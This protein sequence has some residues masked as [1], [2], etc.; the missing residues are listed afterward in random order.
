MQEQSRPFLKHSLKGNQGVTSVSFH[1]FSTITELK[2]S[3]DCQEETLPSF[4]SEIL[5]THVDGTIKLWQLD[6]L[7]G[8]E[9]GAEYEF[10][11]TKEYLAGEGV[12]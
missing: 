1:D 12:H 11:K 2:S 8:K 10:M 6:K 7:N 3:F 9:G 4:T 5:S